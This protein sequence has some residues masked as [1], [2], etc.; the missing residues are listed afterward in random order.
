MDTTP[1]QAGST[2]PPLRPRTAPPRRTVAAGGPS[3]RALPCTGRGCSRWPACR[4]CRRRHTT[5]S[6]PLRRWGSSCRCCRRR[7]YLGLRPGWRQMLPLR[8]T[9]CR[10]LVSVSDLNLGWERGRHVLTIVG[11]QSPSA[12][13]FVH[14]A[15]CLEAV[16]DAGVDEGSD[17]GQ[18]EEGKPSHVD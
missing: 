2:A 15:G 1:H 6:I 12:D 16:A 3:R 9:R 10:S 14:G 4:T 8:G 5:H 18:C 17:R 13:V 11:L 7:W